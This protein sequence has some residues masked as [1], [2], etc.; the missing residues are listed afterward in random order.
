MKSEHLKLVSLNIEGHKH[1]KHIASFMRR[2]RPDVVCLQEVFES[3]FKRL[4]RQLHMQ[5]KFVTM[6]LRPLPN[7]KERLKLG[8]GIL[9]RLPFREIGREYYYGHPRR[10]PYLLPHRTETL[11]RMLLVAKI[12]KG[13]QK[14]VVGTTHFT[15]SPDGRPNK[16]QTKDLPVLL[17]KLK[18]FPEIVFGGD[19][20]APRGGAIFNKITKSYRSNIPRSYKTSLNAKLHYAGKLDL[21]V[22]HIFSTP[23]YVLKRVKLKDGPSDHRA[24]IAEVYRA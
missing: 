10:T 2:E 8:L 20:N 21:V 16:Y 3:D 19:F 7:D 14:F 1:I 11:N 18:K 23:E 24:I 9:T 4:K 12:S 17:R 15:W 13:Q 5:G 22:D 6:T